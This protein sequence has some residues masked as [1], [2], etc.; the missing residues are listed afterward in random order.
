MTTWLE[1]T[2]TRAVLATMLRPRPPGSVAATGGDGTI[3]Y[4]LLGTGAPAGF[5]YQVQ[6]NGDLWVLQ[7]ATHV[8]TITLNQSGN[9][10][11]TEVAP[12]SHPVGSD[13]NNVAFT[14]SF[15]ATDIDN[16][17]TTGTLSISVDDDTPLANND[18]DTMS[19]PGLRPATS[20]LV[21]ARSRV[22]R[23]PITRALTASVRSRTWWVQ[24]PAT[25]TRL[26]GFTAQGAFGT[27]QMDANG[28]YTYTRSGGLGGGQD[29]VF[30][31]TYK[32]GD[33]DTVSAHAD[34]PHPELVPSVPS[35]SGII[36]D[37]DDVVGANGNPGGVGDDAPAKTSGSVAATG[38]DG[39]IT[40][41]LLGTG[42]PA[43]FTYQVQGNGDLWV[44]QGATH[45]LTITLDQT[46][47]YAVT[48]VHADQPSGG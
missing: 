19:L 33:G 11:V 29:D 27:L 35:I 26:G 5:T 46:G 22:R 31:Y 2:V 8:L 23:T 15:T 9:Y 7:G 18:S 48:E 4:A 17:S 21:S 14:V 3:T 37:D 25:T 13:E 16:D 45:V 41:A 1:R 34:D 44:L 42:A 24:P 40:Y 43:G 47:H 28:N 10:T 12:I 20:S 6:G 38:G 36:V 32:D 39:T 30:T